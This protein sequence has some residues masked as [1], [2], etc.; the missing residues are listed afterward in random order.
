M[1]LLAG[2]V[3][4]P[5]KC[6]LRIMLVVAVPFL[7]EEVFPGSLIH[8]TLSMRN[9]ATSFLLFCVFILPPSLSLILILFNAVACYSGLH[10][11]C[12][13]P[14]LFLIISALWWNLDLILTFSRQ[15]SERRYKGSLEFQRN[16]LFLPLQLPDVSA[17]CVLKYA[18][19]SLLNAYCIVYLEVCNNA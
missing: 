19:Q 12:N 7:T 10:T 16:W 14:L 6:F 4:C 8:R 5:R 1:V 11:D 13:K 15:R 2:F 3:Y 18:P 9:P 17:M